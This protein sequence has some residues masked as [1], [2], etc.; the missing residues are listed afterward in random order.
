MCRCSA[1]VSSTLSHPLRMLRCRRLYIST[2]G[3]RT[4]THVIRAGLVP[5]LLPPLLVVGIEL[6]W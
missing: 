5:P 2:I 3:P 4:T 1:I 6:L